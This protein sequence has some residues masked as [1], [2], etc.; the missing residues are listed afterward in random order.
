MSGNEKSSSRDFGDSSQLTNWIL[1]S[2]ST[3]YM[4][5]QLLDFIPGSLEDKDKYIEVAYG[6]HGTVKQKGQS[7]IKLYTNNGDTSI[8][9]LHNLLL[10]PDLCNGLFSIITLMNLVHTCLF[11]KVFSNVYFGEK[12]KISVSLPHSAQIKH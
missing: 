9:T 6:H 3:C 10:G 5:P 7:Q 11:H 1:D 4:T 8:A 2:V 12:E